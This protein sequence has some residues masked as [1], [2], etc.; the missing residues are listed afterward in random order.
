MHQ[1]KVY[2]AENNIYTQSIFALTDLSVPELTKNIEEHKLL[3]SKD[4]TE[5]QSVTD[6]LPIPYN[7]RVH[8]HIPINQN[9]FPVEFLSSTQNAILQAFTYIQ[10][11]DSCRP[12]LE[13]ETYTWLNFL[14]EEKDQK[15]AL[16]SGLHNEFIWLE[17]ELNKRQLLAK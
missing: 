14:T 2:P 6:I 12:L 8:Y 5:S 16:I 15:Y 10:M 7:V 17:A 3:K 13:I 9:N 1:T 4:K 11:N